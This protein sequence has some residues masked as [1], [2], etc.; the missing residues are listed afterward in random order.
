M[1]TTIIIKETK[2]FK[3]VCIQCERIINLNLKGYGTQKMMEKVEEIFF[4]VMQKN[5]G[6]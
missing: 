3:S 1:A 5:G 6:Y 4:K 2:T